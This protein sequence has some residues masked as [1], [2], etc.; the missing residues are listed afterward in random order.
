MNF[1]L[2]FVRDEALYEEL[3]IAVLRQGNRIKSLVAF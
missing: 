1:F 3:N 2:T